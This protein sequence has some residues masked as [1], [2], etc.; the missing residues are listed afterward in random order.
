MCVT[1]KNLSPAKLDK[2]VQECYKY[3]RNGENTQDHSILLSFL[4]LF[5]FLT[6]AIDIRVFLFTSRVY[7]SGA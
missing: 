6:L 7:V 3:V 2:R 1:D 4:S 5:F